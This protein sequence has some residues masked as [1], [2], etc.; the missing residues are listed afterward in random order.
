MVL[1]QGEK[2]V[3][4][5]AFMCERERVVATLDRTTTTN[6]AMRIGGKAVRLGVESAAGTVKQL[7]SK[8]E[9]IEGYYG[10]D[11][12]VAQMLRAMLGDDG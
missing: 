9:E 11:S 4:V 6:E 1:T 8:R 3:W 5:A 2:M 12:D 7:R 10:E